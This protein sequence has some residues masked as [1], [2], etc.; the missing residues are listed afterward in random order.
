[1]ESKR[2]ACLKVFGWFGGAA[3][4]PWWTQ[5]WSEGVG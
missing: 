5:P 3:A 1:M 4:G 2:L